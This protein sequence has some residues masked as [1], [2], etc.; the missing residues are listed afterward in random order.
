ML[1]IIGLFIIIFFITS[2]PSR[3][4]DFNFKDAYEFYK[5][6]Y[7]SKDGRIIDNSKKFITTS[8]GQSYMLM[9]SFLI[10][11]KKT[12]DLVYDWSKNNLQRKDGLF[13]WLW[14]ETSDGGWGIL[15]KN[16]ASDSDIDIAFALISAYEKWG[17]RTYLTEAKRI[18]NA[19]W[20]YETK[21]IG[22]YR[23]LMPGVAQ[24]LSQDIEINPSYFSPYSFKL[25]QKYDTSHDWSKLVDSSYYY[26]EKVNSITSSG[27]PPDWF[28][29][30]NGKIVLK[31]GRSDFSY[32][33]VRVFLR[34]FLDYK[35]TGD[36]RALPILEK[37]KFFIKKWQ[38]FS[39]LYTNYKPDGTLKDHDEFIGSI[40]LLVPII[41]LYDEKTAERIYNKNLKPYFKQKGYWNNTKEYYGQNLLW[42]GCYLY[43]N[44]D[45]NREK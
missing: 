41:D 3:G 8:E 7:M 2:P 29:I 23:V 34:V 17:E 24:T 45:I 11:D 31:E 42:F 33:A 19:I 21:E 26:L 32:D 39:R 6:Y 18:I 35:L 10:D 40:A 22:K 12:F 43:K 30:K 38:P 25:F 9:Q 13:S 28:Y 37:S 5:Y 36:K 27:L 16:S 20:T 1:L 44:F 15:D 4:E 14:G